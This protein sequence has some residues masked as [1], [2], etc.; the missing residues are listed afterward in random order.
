MPKLE[1]PKC[2]C[3]EVHF[4]DRHETV[5]MGTLSLEKVI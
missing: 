4:E 3:G 2:K 1:P 5:P